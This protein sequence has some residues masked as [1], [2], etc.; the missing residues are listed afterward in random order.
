VPSVKRKVLFGRILFETSFCFEDIYHCMSDEEKARV[1]QMD[2]EAFEAFLERNAKGI[3]GGFEGGLLSDWTGVAST[4]ASN[5]DYGQ[6]KEY[7]CDHHYHPIGE[8]DQNGR[9]RCTNCNH[10]I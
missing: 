7:S 6:K 1:D 3:Q 5:L 10:E 2:D 8:Y 9:F 4:I